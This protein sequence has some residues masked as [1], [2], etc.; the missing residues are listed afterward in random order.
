LST[1]P[2]NR[3]LSHGFRKAYAVQNIGELPYHS[4]WTQPYGTYLALGSF[5]LLSIIN[6][7]NVFF[8]GY[9]TASS[10][11]TAYIGIPMFLFLYLGHRFTVG[12]NDKWAHN[13]V[14]VDMTTGVQE[15]ID[16]EIKEGKQG[17]RTFME[18]MAVWFL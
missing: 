1:S 15:I 13:A 9:F 10:F 14:D 4:T 7:F 2:L 6:G 11:L 18:R 12:K 3:A 5:S 16:A 8:P 17:P